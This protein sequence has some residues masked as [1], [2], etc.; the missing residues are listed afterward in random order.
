M[1]S[2]MMAQMQWK[3]HQLAQV[4]ALVEK[5]IETKHTF[6]RTRLSMETARKTGKDSSMVAARGASSPHERR[7]PACKNQRVTGIQEVIFSTLV[8]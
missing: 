2:Q 5:E 3:C 8:S 7:R 4:L 1:R 6:T